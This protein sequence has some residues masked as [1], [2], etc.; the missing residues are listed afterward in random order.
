MNKYIKLS[1][2]LCALSLPASVIAVNFTWVNWTTDQDWSNGGN[3]NKGGLVP[4]TADETHFNQGPGVLGPIVSSNNAVTG[5]IVVDNGSSLTIA[6]GASLNNSGQVVMGN[7]FGSTSNSI[8]AIGTLDVATEFGLG[9]VSG[10]DGILTVNIGGT[11][12][13]LNSWLISG[14]GDG[15]TGYIIMDG[16]TLNAKDLWVGNLG[17]GNLT[18]NSGSVNATNV[19]NVAVGNSSTGHVTV[20]GGM[21]TVAGLNA[22]ANDGTAI[23]NLNGGQVINNGGFVQNTNAVFNFDGGELVFTLPAFTLE[24]V[25]WAIDNGGGTWNFAE[26]RSVVEV[27]GNIIISSVTAAAPTIISLTAVSNGVMKM[28]VDAQ[29]TGNNY[30]PIADNDLTVASWTTVEHS[31]NPT[32]GFAVTNL[33]YS[34]TSGTNKVIYVQSTEAQKFFKIGV[35]QP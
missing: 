33:D 35:V 29:S 26:A 7:G 11:V 5:R 10:C 20:N 1:L 19:L 9:M 23:L 25:N 27:G 3:W 22:G 14:Y 34:T 13:A 17:N 21:L 18:V 16:G 32:T 30:Y 2:L 12:N 6:G 8:V 31:D 24:D 28:V 15:G 4:T